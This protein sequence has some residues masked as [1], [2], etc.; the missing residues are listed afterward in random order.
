MHFFELN[1]LSTA[2]RVCIARTV[3]WQD[4]CPSVRLFVCLS[5]AGT[6]SK[7]LNIRSF[8][9]VGSQT[10]LVFPYQT[11]WQYSDEHP[12]MGASN[13]K[14]YE[15]ITIFDKYMYF[16]FVSEIDARQNHSYYGRRIRNR[17][18]AV[19]WY[20][21]EWPRVYLTQISRPWYYSTSNNKAV[22]DIS[23]LTMADQQKVVYGLS[24]GDRYFQ[25]P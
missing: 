3:P 4:V 14:G 2:R 25:W 18:Q 17:T 24:N 1:V 12:L 22:Q 20:P 15:K 16:R 8:F 11:G 7:R 5:H 13:A 19:E 21:F 9:T 6:L 23:I 10:I